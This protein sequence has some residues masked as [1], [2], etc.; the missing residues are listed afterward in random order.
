MI[1]NSP[2]SNTP[3]GPLNLSALARQ[4]F[5]F[6]WQQI[7]DGSFQMG[8]WDRLK[9]DLFGAVIDEAQKRLNP[10]SDIELADKLMISRHTIIRKRSA[11]SAKKN[12]ISPL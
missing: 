8:Y 11:F 6:I 3:D 2:L 10:K 7:R 1:A 5:E 12:S 4:I 9:E